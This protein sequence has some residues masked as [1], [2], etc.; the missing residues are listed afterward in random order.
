MP[1]DLVP[2]SHKMSVLGHLPMKSDATSMKPVKTEH[3][4]PFL[5]PRREMSVEGMPAPLSSPLVD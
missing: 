2:I 4:S 5:G 1:F 3:D